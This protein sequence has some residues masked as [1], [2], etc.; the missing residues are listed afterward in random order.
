MTIN[1]PIAAPETPEEY[2][3]RATMWGGEKT[4]PTNA[5]DMLFTTSLFCAVQMILQQLRQL[6]EDVAEL[7]AKL[8]G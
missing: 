7:N 3:A 2:L 1:I 5:R 4:I 8:E 6:E